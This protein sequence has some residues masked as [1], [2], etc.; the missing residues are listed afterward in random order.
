MQLYHKLTCIGLT[1]ALRANQEAIEICALHPINKN[2]L[3]NKKI[4]E[5]LILEG[6]P[7][8]ANLNY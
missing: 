6:F 3:I 5:I 1:E 2:F 7:D 4:N 8:H